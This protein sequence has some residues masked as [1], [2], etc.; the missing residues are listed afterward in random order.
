MP[1]RA[2]IDLQI[3]FAPCRAPPWRYSWKGLRCLPVVFVDEATETIAAH[4]RPSG[5]SEGE[6]RSTLGYSQVEAAVG[7]SR[8]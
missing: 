6:W 4:D 8:L 1:G 3:R 5:S 2:S 7:T